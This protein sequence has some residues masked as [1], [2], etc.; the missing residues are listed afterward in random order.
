MS[1]GNSSRLTVRLEPQI[2]SKFERLRHRRL[3]PGQPHVFINQQI[4]ELLALALEG[5]MDRIIERLDK[6]G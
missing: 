6:A 4:N 1:T 3:K 2:Q 5:P